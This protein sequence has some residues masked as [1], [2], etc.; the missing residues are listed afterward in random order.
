MKGNC[1]PPLCRWPCDEEVERL[2]TAFERESNSEKRKELADQIQIR[3][4]D[5]VV[6]IPLGQWYE[7]LAYRRGVLGGVPTGPVPFL[8]GIDKHGR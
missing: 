3:A 5:V 2:R 6:Q 8:W 7:R 4:M 1:W